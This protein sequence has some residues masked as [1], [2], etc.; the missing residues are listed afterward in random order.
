MITRR[1]SQTIR[2]EITSFES[3]DRMIVKVYQDR[4]SMTYSTKTNPAK[5]QSAKARC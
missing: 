4:S 1:R 5:N 3:V 2:M